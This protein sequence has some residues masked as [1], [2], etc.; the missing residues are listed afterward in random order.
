MITLSATRLE[1]E[2]PAGC[3][4]V[5]AHTES[6][7]ISASLGGNEVP[8]EVKLPKGLSKSQNFLVKFGQSEFR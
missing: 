5:P 1:K 7:P 2:A 3:G 6:P 4:A 8:A